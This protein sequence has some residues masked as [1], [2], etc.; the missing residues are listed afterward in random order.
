[1]SQTSPCLKCQFTVTKQSTEGKK[2]D[3]ET[4]ELN[5]NHIALLTGDLQKALCKKK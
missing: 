1:M 4:K 3:G 5:S 2:S